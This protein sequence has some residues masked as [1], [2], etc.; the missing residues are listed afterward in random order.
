MKNQ[1]AI[2]GKLGGAWEWGYSSNDHTLVNFTVWRWT[3]ML[4]IT[5]CN[6]TVLVQGLLLIKDKYGIYEEEYQNLLRLRSSLVPR[7]L[8]MFFYMGK[9]LG[10]RLCYPL[11]TCSDMTHKHTHPPY[12]LHVPDWSTMWETSCHKCS[13]EG[14]YSKTSKTIG[15]YSFTV[16]G[17]NFALAEESVHGPLYRV[18]TWEV[19]ASCRF[20][21]TSS[22]VKS[23]GGKWP[24][25]CIEV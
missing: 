1:T 19:S 14:Y 9:S 18:E 13:A 5:F 4:Q 20:K 22:K 21:C 24:V 2:N 11:Y 12:V 10:T 25:H 16:F 7:L 6:L 23:I 15:E 8:P 17:G 3:E